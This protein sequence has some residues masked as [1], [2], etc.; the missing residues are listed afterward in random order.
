V[1]KEFYVRMIYVCIYVCGCKLE[2][3]KLRIE[4]TVVEYFKQRLLWWL[5]CGFP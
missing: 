4:V 5:L 3:V 1:K 2:V